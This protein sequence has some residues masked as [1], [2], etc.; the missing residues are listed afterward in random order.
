MVGTTRFEL[1]TSPTP[2]VRSTR[3]SHV[4]THVS[5]AARVGRLRESRSIKCTPSRATPNQV[6]GFPERSLRGYGERGLRE[7][8][9]GPR[10]LTAGNPVRPH[11]LSA[12]TRWASPLR[13]IRRW[14][15]VLRAVC[16][17]ARGHALLR[18]RAAFALAEEEAVHLLHQKIL[19]LPRPRLQPVLIQQHLL[20]LH[21]LAPRLLRHVLVDLLAEVGVERRFVQP[22]QLSLVLGAK[23]HVRHRIVLLV[24]SDCNG[25]Q[26][27]LLLPFFPP[28]FNLPRFAGVA[29]PCFARRSPLACASASAALP[30]RSA[31]LSPSSVSAP[32]ANFGRLC[33]RSMRSSSTRTRIPILNARP[34]RVLTICLSVSRKTNRS[35][36]PQPLSNVI[37]TRPSINK[38]SSST[39]NPYLVHDRMIPPK[40]SPTRSSMNR[41]FFHSISSRSASS[42]RRSAWLDYAAIAASSGSGIGSHRYPAARSPPIFVTG[43]VS[44]FQGC[45]SVLRIAP[46]RASAPLRSNSRISRCTIKSG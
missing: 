5:H 11:S 36:L 33:C 44:C 27:R 46:P 38:S 14:I 13:R 24:S 37:G 35:S 10:S 42:A 45:G 29:L 3:L 25:V 26:R 31:F 16:L 4:P 20:P 2:R 23:N 21:P 32:S 7:L 8:V 19:C 22:L 17:G 6:R 41:I 18:Q 39:K 1:A 34:P 9:G 15:N 40:S 30:F 43:T 28:A 12:A